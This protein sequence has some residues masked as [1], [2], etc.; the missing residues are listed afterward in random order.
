MLDFSERNGH[1]TGV[2]PRRR[3]LSSICRAGLAGGVISV[4]LAGGVACRRGP[5]DAGLIRR[6]TEKLAVAAEKGDGAAIEAA[7]QA[8]YRDGEGRGRSETRRLLEEY[9]ARRSGIVVH[10]LEVKIVTLRLPRAEV[11]ADVALSSGA[12]E[13]LRRIVRFSGECYRFHCRLTREGAEW[14]VTSTE[15]EPIATV[16]LSGSALKTLREIFPLL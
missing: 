6:L 2:M 10:L 16:D 9:H 4:L 5:D 7:L 13:A 14:K 1:S 15:W 8:D 11:D 3:F 12:G